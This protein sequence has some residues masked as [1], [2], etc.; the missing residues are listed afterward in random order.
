M[1]P[2]LIVAIPIVLVIVGMV[3]NSIG[4]S[5]DQPPSSSEQDPA[6]RAAAEGETYRRFFDLQR[7]RATKT[8]EGRPVCLVAYGAIIGSFIWL[9][10]YAEQNHRHNS[11]C[12][13]SDTGDEEGKRCSLAHA[14]GW[15][16]CQIPDQSTHSRCL[17]SRQE[18]RNFETEGLILRHGTIRHGLDYRRESI[19]CRRRTESVQRPDSKKRLK[20][21]PRRR[22]RGG[23]CNPGSGDQLHN[24]RFRQP[25]LSDFRMSLLTS[26]MVPG[27]PKLPG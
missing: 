11:N 2:M 17:G 23:F 3:L 25:R 9:Y 10:L 5:F 8:K 6:K 7:K 22:K 4:L 26:S 1:H 19:A 24:P 13:A 21:K 27:L 16:Q 14:E 12:R 15:E 18:R 20:V